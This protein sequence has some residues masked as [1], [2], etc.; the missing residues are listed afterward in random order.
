MV[1]EKVGVGG[2]ERWEDMGCRVEKKERWWRKREGECENKDEGNGK[3]GQDNRKEE[4]LVP[5]KRRKKG[6]R[7]REKRKRGK[8]RVERD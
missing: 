3:N 8:K 5:K 2:E 1:G 7:E 6:R 4:E